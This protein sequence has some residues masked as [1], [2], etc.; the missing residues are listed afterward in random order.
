MGANPQGLPLPQREMYF[1]IHNIYANFFKDSLDYF[2]LHLYPRF[3][4]RVVATY[5]K[6][7]EYI[8]KTCQY[9]REMDRPT[10]P[11]LILNPSGYLSKFPSVISI[12]NCSMFLP[13]IL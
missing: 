11:A 1:F 8:T 2:S 10:L 7:V 12:S 5:D 13:Y 4:H 6:A 3:E 9:D